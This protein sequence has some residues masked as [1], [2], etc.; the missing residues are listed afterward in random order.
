MPSRA[1]LRSGVETALRALSI[2][3]LALMLW[4]SLDR[5]RTESIASAHSANLAAAVRDWSASGMAPDRVSLDLQRNPVPAHRDWIRALAHAGTQLSWSG[6]LPAAAVSVQPVPSPRGGFTVLAAAPA[7]NRV[8]IEDDLGLIEGASAAAGGAGFHLPMASGNVIARAGGT[9]A[10]ASLPDSVRVG[11]LLILGAAGWE[12]KF[13]TA[14]LEEDGWR[15]DAEIRVAPG[16][17]VSQGNSSPIDTARYSAVVVLDGTAASRASDIARYVASGGG[18][19]LSGGAA[20]VDAFA[21]LRAGAPGRIQSPS[22]TEGEPGSVTVASLARFPITALRSDAI[23]LASDNG[24]TVSAARRHFAGRVLQS[25]YSDTWRWRMSGGDD[26]P[27]DHR[28]WWTNL[29]ASVAYAPA[30]KR[31]VIVTDNAPY[32]GLVAALGPPAR[33]PGS[34]LASAAGSISLWLLFAILSLSLL[35]EWASRRLRGSR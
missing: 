11:R 13:V 23:R 26:S 35:G 7:A 6:Q 14:A 5:G 9:T 22:A 30:V 15:V 24:E 18:L 31:S 8:S 33:Q 29:V 16:V 32:A 10:R 1:E 17:S 28:S 12:T 4:V 2:A 19:V 20:S 21:S 25:G 27:A 34:N 3:I